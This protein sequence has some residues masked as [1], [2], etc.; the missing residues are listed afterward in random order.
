M[1]VTKEPSA[2]GTDR[3]VSRLTGW[4]LLMLPAFVVVFFVTSVVGEYVVLDLLGLPEGSLFLMEG[5][6]AGWT[7]EVLMAVLLATAPVVGVWFA[8][9]AL[10]RGAQRKAWAGLVLNG[11]LVVWVAYMLF[12][13]IRMSYFAPLD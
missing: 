1:S 8:V 7:A 6:V 10:R 3:Q 13:A 11:L 9:R 2:S 5:G 4:S 12:D